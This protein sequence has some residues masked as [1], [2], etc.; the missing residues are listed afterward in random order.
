MTGRYGNLDYARLTKLGVAAG[1]ALFVGG[2]LGGVAGPAVSGP[3]PDW[4][5]TLLLDIEALGIVFMLLS[6]LVFGVALPLTE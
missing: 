5:R 1:L 6:P 4:E 3:L 2:A